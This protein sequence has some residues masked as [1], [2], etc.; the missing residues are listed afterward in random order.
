[1]LLL[2]YWEN[3]LLFVCLLLGGVDAYSF[4]KIKYNWF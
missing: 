3:Y 4:I 1:M 2:L